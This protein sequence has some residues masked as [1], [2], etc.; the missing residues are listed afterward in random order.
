M[1][2]P[3]TSKFTSR[4]SCCRCIPSS[5]LVVALLLTVIAL[6]GVTMSFEDEIQ[7]SLNAGMTRVEARSMPVLTPDELTTRS[8]GEP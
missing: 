4:P 6:T 2:L 3:I 1:T 5:G 8:P 7:A